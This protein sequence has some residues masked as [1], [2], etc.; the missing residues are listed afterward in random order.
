[1]NLAKL[2]VSSTAQ[3]IPNRFEKWDILLRNVATQR[4]QSNPTFLTIMAEHHHHLNKNNKI[5]PK[6]KT[7]KPVW[8]LKML[9]LG[10]AHYFVSTAC[11]TR[12]R[13]LDW[14]K[15]RIRNFSLCF[16]G[17]WG[18][19]L[20]SSDDWRVLWHTC[21]LPTALSSQA[22][23]LLTAG[24]SNHLL[25]VFPHANTRLYLFR[26]CRGRKGAWIVTCTVVY[27]SASA[28]RFAA[29]LV[30]LNGKQ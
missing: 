2:S 28:T 7:K 24:G 12:Q 3:Y 30:C 11:Q 19:R 15:F 23:T 20:R 5:R 22:R 9:T 13:Q 14:L 6:K 16:Y 27:T 26:G 25:P 29:Y 18:G 21:S 8:I 10:R 17:R 1:M 4:H